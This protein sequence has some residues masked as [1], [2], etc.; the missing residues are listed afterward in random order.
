MANLVLSAR[1]LNLTENVDKNLQAHIRL[2][3][4]TQDDG[5][6]NQFSLEEIQRSRYLRLDSAA[7]K[8]LN[9]EP[10]NT[11]ESVLSSAD[12]ATS[13][14]LGLLDKCRTAQ[15][16]RL[17]C[18]WIRQPLRDLALIRE[19]HE[20]VA[21]LLDDSDLRSSLS[22]EYLRRVPDLQQLGKRLLRKKAGLQECYK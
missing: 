18:Q 19:R 11:G 1:Q 3:Q 21:T 12:S 10:R 7:I 6:A 5:N 15:G 14:L 4:L 8:A 9:V 16:H 13:S 2:P 17:L 22:E 20:V